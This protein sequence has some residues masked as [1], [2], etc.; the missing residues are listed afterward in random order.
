MIDDITMTFNSVDLSDY[1]STYAVAHEVE[2]ADLLTAMD[3]TEYSAVRERP[4]VTISFL[5]MS[6]TTAATIYSALSALIADLSYTDPWLGER[7]A[8]FRITSNIDAVFGLNSVDG[9]IYYKGGYVVFRQRA[10]L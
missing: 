4:I 7:T 2:V 3:G 6:S 1:L 10:V 8:V 5:P 9:S